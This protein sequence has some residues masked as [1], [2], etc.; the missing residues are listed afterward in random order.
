[1]TPCSLVSGYRDFGGTHNL[2]HFWGHRQLVSP[3]RP[4]TP[5]KVQGVAIQ[6]ATLLE[7]I[8]F[9]SYS[10]YRTEYINTTEKNEEFCMLKQVV[11][12]V[13]TCSKG[14]NNSTEGHNLLL[15]PTL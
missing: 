2:L 12:F 1:V 10:E 6:K 5:T 9:Y 15:I 14:L 11:H 8:N 7:V 4:Y 3:K 13:T